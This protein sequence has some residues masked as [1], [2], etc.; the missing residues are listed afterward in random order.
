MSEKEFEELIKETLEQQSAK[1]REHQLSALLHL[2]YRKSSLKEKKAVYSFETADWMRNLYGGLHGGIVCSVFDTGMGCTSAALSGKMV[3]TTDL[4][5]SFQRALLGEHFL[6]VV[7][8][9]HNGGRLVSS[10]SRILD[11]DSGEIMATAMGS[12]MNLDAELRG[13]KV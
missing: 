6:L 9:T 11:E 5:V 3:T 12:F 7:Q 10:Q 1:G 8:C 13:I 4:T 2:K